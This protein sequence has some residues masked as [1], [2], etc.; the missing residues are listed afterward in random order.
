MIEKFVGPDGEEYADLNLVYQSIDQL[1]N[2]ELLDLDN[3]PMIYPLSLK[4]LTK[5]ADG[6]YKMKDVADR[7]EAALRAYEEIP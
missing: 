7:F 2:M 1:R 6:L 3:P 5:N 4:G